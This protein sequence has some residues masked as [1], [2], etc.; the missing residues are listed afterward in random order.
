[1]YDDIDILTS[2]K[3]L[4]YI[5]V[6]T[7]HSDLYLLDFFTDKSVSACV[8]RGFQDHFELDL[9]S[10]PLAS[11]RKRILQSSSL[12]QLCLRHEIRLVLVVQA[13]MLTTV[14]ASLGILLIYSCSHAGAFC[15]YS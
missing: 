11:P 5:S 12:S 1:M 7:I 14:I 4:Q 6:L 13:G 15:D 8:Q 2:Y 3:G 9:N 10:G